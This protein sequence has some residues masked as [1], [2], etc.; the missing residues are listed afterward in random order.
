M[1]L[2]AILAHDDG[3]GIGINNKLPWHIKEDLAFFKKMTKNNT[4]IMGRKTFESLGNK[5]LP[6]RLN[7]VLSSQIPKEPIENVKFFQTK[8]ALLYNQKYFEGE[9]FIIGG[10]QIYEL[11][12]KGIDTYYVTQVKGTHQC[13]AFVHN[14][15]TY[16]NTF[17]KEQ[18]EKYTNCTMFKYY[19]K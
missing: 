1:T 2:N 14:I 13:D 3:F 4:V 8:E 19:K 15:N 10:S 17:E 16:L 5:P 18:L 9:T 11:F 12:K 6:N 7:I